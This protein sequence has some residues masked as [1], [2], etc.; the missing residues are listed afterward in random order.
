MQRIPRESSGWTE[1]RVL[2]R[3]STPL[4]SSSSRFRSDRL[5]TRLKDRR[6]PFLGPVRHTGAAQRSNMDGTRDTAASLIKRL[7]RR[8]SQSAKSASHGRRL[9]SKILVLCPS[10][11]DWRFISPW[12]T[13]V[14]PIPRFFLRLP[15][16]P[17]RFLFYYVLPLLLRW[18]MFDEWLCTYVYVFGHGACSRWGEGGGANETRRGTGR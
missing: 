16:P 11:F 5:E 1:P 2:S 6:N 7:F 18:L 8:K 17:P 4:N 3:D 10:P 15:P 9:A 12:S 14:R 13:L